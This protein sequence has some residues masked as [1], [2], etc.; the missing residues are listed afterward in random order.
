MEAEGPPDKMPIFFAEG[1][2][3][4]HISNGENDHLIE[5]YGLTPISDW[6]TATIPG[7]RHLQS[8]RCEPY[9]S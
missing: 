2:Y 7:T 3:V 5:I 8:L 1:K 4:A 9:V 6:C